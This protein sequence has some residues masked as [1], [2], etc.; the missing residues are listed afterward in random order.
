MSPKGP[1]TQIFADVPSIWE[2]FLSA[3]GKIK[4]KMWELLLLWGSPQGNS[5]LIYTGPWLRVRSG[6]Q[7]GSFR[8]SSP[9]FRW[10]LTGFVASSPG[11]ASSPTPSYLKKEHPLLLLTFSANASFFVALNPTPNHLFCLFV[12]YPG[13]QDPSCVLHSQCLVYNKCSKNFCSMNDGWVDEW[14]ER[15]IDGKSDKIKKDQVRKELW[16]IIWWQHLIN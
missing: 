5:K 3:V 9:P 10:G 16:N 1:S 13:G 14:K 6:G 12:L 2:V 11:R 7:N 8:G 4:K 15:W